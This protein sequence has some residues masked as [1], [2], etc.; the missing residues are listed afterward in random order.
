M[1]INDIFYVK[2]KENEWMWA[3]RVQKWNARE[4]W[5]YL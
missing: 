4:F 2:S 3:F 1:T 5:E